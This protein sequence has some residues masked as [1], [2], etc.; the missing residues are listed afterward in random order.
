M[1]EAKTKRLLLSRSGGY[2][3]NP[4]CNTDLFS[5][6]ETGEITNIEELA[7]IIGQSKKGPR[8]DST[9]K[10]TERD[11]YENIVLL[12]PTCHTRVD[13]FP[14]LYPEE[15]IKEWKK[16]HEDKI[17]ALFHVP[18]FPSRIEASLAIS[19]LQNENKM[20]FDTYGPNSKLAKNNPL[21]TQGFWEQ[22]AIDTIIPNN[23][24]VFSIIDTNYELLT[25]AEKITYEEWKQH[26]ES[27]EYNKLSGDYTSALIF[28]PPKFNSILNG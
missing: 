22:K 17:K 25:D 1:I 13:K 14:K 18:K 3:G 20:V 19:K 2:C 16:N 21:E 4:E 24:K 5:F 9:L 7:H 6:F 10:L 28:Y 15:Q 12:C 27:F 8:G 26:K 23:R 11:T